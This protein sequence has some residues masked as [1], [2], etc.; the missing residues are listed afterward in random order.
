MTSLQYF[1]NIS[2]YISPKNKKNR[3]F[4]ESARNGL[5]NNVQY[6]I[7]RP[8]GSREIQQT[9]VGAVLVDT[10]YNIHGIAHARTNR[11][12]DIFLQRRQGQQTCK[13]SRLY[14]FRAYTTLVV[15]V[16][17]SVNHSVIAC[18]GIVF[19]YC[20][21]LYFLGPARQY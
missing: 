17:P 2:F 19:L 13:K 6:G 8:L 4:L 1:D 20:K 5:L 12:D 21:I 3:I 11:K 18:Y 14:P 9:K 7:S 15:L 10:Q 16:L